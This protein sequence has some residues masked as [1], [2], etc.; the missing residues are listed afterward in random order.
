MIPEVFTERLVLRPFRLADLDAWAAIV[1]DP[2]VMTYI[3]TGGPVE[4][5]VAWR[6]LAFHLGEWALRGRGS[7]VVERRSDGALI[8]RTGFLEPLGWPGEELAWMFARAA[9]GQGYATEA[10]A[11]ARDFGR[12]HLG[13]GPLISMIRP[14]NAPSRRLAERLGAVDGGTIEFLGGAAHVYRHP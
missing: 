1:A 7:W 2:E 5:D 11:A 8:G 3:G 9:W 13:A 4:R 10:T 12:R 6:Q 14:A